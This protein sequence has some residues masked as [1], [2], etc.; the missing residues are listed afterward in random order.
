[1]PKSNPEF[2]EKISFFNSLTKQTMKLI[3]VFFTKNVKVVTLMLGILLSM[4]QMASA[5]GMRV[6]WNKFEVVVNEKN[7]VILT[8]N[9]T[10]YNN[11]SFR[12]QHSVD[13]AKWE[14]IAIVQSQNSP[15]SMTDYSY[16]HRIKLSGKQFYRLQ[17]LDIDFN[18]TGFSPVKT[19]SVTNEKPVI[20]LWPN[21]AT[22]EISLVG[23]HDSNN[24]SYTKAQIFDLS[25][26]LL[27]EKKFTEGSGTI[28]IHDL[29]TG[30]YILRVLS[31]NGT[32]HTE[33][34]VKQ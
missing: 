10:E 32:I 30:T 14:D 1:V 26:K 28:N 12:V 20:S 6:F 24:G 23:A 33:K 7:E 15:E 3:S 21:P 31:T 18:S 11:K 34:F 13:G 2:D 9:V 27:S 17:D 19:V 22:N 25:G 8:W 29:Q 16:V 4:T 5:A